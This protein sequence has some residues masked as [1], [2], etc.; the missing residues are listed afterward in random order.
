MNEVGKKCPVCSTDAGLISVGS[1]AP[2]S[3]MKCASC[4]VVFFDP[5]KAPGASWYET[6]GSYAEFNLISGILPVLPG[7]WHRQFLARPGRLGE[8][9]LDIGCGTGVFLHEARKLGYRVAGIDFNS[10]SIRIAKERF[11]IKEVERMSVEEYFRKNPDRKFDAC[12]FFEVLEHLEDPSRFITGVGSL[13]KPGGHIALSVPN[14][15]RAVDHLGDEDYP[16]NHLTRWSAGALKRFLEKNGFRV[17]RMV[18][19]EMTLDD[20]IESATK[21]IMLK[22][23][24]RLARKAVSARG[25]DSPLALRRYSTLKSIK[26][27]VLRAIFSPAAPFLKLLRPQGFHI[28]CEASVKGRPGE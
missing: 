27:A 9:L 26:N 7:W 23:K 28:Y 17:E 6:T 5:M 19:Q 1:R 24:G 15:E 3:I 14:R 25:G 22:L 12:T 20:L 18:V 16:P 4:D 13:L 10:E 21:N 8:D 2:Y 11:G